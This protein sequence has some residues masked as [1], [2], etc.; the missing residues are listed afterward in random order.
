MHCGGLKGR[1]AWTR[2]ADSLF[3]PV[4]TNTAL[5]SNTTAIEINLKKIKNQGAE[6]DG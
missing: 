3:S 1:Q 2:V 6:Q 5:Q 4:E